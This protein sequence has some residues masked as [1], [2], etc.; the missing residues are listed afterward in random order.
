MLDVAVLVARD[1]DHSPPLPQAQRLDKSAAQAVELDVTQD[2][3][4]SKHHGSEAAAEAVRTMPG[5]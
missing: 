5:D 2:S 3:G 4:N 1:E